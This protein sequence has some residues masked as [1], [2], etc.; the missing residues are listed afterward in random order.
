ML[1]ILALSSMMR[2]SPDRNRKRPA[3]PAASDMYLSQHIVSN[4]ANEQITRSGKRTKNERIQF[5]SEPKSYPSI[6]GCFGGPLILPP[7]G[8]FMTTMI[9]EPLVASLR[10]KSGRHAT[11]P[12]WMT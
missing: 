12:P 11:H 3:L 2:L 9:G 4:G 10:R 5:S 8:G 1:G 6:R 7:G